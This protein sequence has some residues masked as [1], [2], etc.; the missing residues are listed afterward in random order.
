MK[1]LLP[2]V[3]T[4]FICGL[5]TLDVT[6]AASGSALTYQGGLMASGAP[7]NGNYDLAFSL[8]NASSGGTQLSSTVTNTGVI[9]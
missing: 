5:A 1:T 3:W 7:A 4:I 2:L 6:E 9:M 8:F